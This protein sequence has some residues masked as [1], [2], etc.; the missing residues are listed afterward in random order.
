MGN[1]SRDPRVE[2]QNALDR[3]YVAVRFQQGKPALDRELNLAADLA[4]PRRVAAQYIGNGVADGFEIRGL[5]VAANDFTIT[6]GRALVNGLEAVLRADTTYRTQ[7]VR[8]SVGSLPAGASNVYLRV[9]TREAGAA[10]DP[11]LAN[12]ADVGF[13]TAVRDRVV[14]EVIVSQPAISAPDHLLL[15]T[16][17][18]APSQILDRRL[19]GMTLAGVGGEVRGARGTRASLDDRLDQS[20]QANGALRPNSVG[21]TQ[22]ADAAVTIGKLAAT[23]VLDRT[24]VAPG[25]SIGDPPTELVLTLLQTEEPAFFLVSVHIN[26]ARPV[27]LERPTIEWRQRTQLVQPSLSNPAHEHHYQ[28]VLQNS[29]IIQQNVTIRAYRLLEA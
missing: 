7:P 25:H 26:G 19:A 4:S 27:G 11:L 16:L 1:F 10:D 21:R 8:T 24:M 23:L 2:L 22:I 14:W 3:D 6:A 13:E 9:A 20:L 18:T 29:S 12:A 28:L 15:A 5:N 17:A